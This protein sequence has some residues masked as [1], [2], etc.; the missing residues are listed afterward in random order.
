MLTRVIKCL[1]IS[2]FP[3]L[4]LI[5]QLL[6]APRFYSLSS[7]SDPES[8]VPDN[9]GTTAA[10]SPI[11]QDQNEA[12]AKTALAVLNHPLRILIMNCQSIRNKKTEPHTI[13]RY[14]FGE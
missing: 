6:L 11:V 7:L 8:P 14:H 4:N 13:T 2:T 10:S 3:L 1:Y 9:I 5:L 12:R